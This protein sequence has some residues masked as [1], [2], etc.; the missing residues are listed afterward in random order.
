MAANNQPQLQVRS[1]CTVLVVAA[2]ITLLPIGVAAI[3]TLVAVQGEA[4]TDAQPASTRG[5]LKTLP[6]S[7]R[8]EDDWLNN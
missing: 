6:L 7:E 8:L 3:S 2:I 4:I 5:W 1:Y